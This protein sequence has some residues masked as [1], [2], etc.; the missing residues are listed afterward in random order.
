MRLRN[1][2]QADEILARSPYVRHDPAACRGRWRQHFPRPDPIRL[3]IGMGKGRFIAE[4][5]DLHADLNFI[6]MDRYGSVLCKAAQKL[7]K[8]P[9]V[10]ANLALLCA[11]ARGVDAIF[12][13]GEVECI[14]LNFPDPWPKE[15]HSKRRLCSDRFL[16]IYGGILAPGGRLELKTD[17]EQFFCFAREELEAAEWRILALT[18]DLHRD[19]ALMADN[20]MTEYEERFTRLGH[21]I[22]KLTAAPPPHPR[23]ESPWH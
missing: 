22:M 12:A 16:P 6:G 17:N 19:A 21:R 13:A 2:P 8:T 9:P 7:E 15:R 11:D 14:Y 20:V 10:A 5:A 18:G 3:E 1:V 4:M 23:K